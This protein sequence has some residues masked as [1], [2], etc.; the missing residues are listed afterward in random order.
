TPFR[1]LLD[2]EASGGRKGTEADALSFADFVRSAHAEMSEAERASF[3]KGLL[4][5]DYSIH[6]HVF[7]RS[8]FERVLLHACAGSTVLALAGNA[9]EGQLEHIAILRKDAPPDRRPVDVVIPIYN[10]RELTR[11]CVESVL[12]HS[13]ADA[14]IVLLDDA[15]S[16]PGITEDLD[17]FARR[18]R[19]V[20][21]RNEKNEG[22]V[23][24]ANRG[25]RHAA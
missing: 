18:E 5:T 13:P 21:L 17:A 6:F 22:F 12:R 7:D 24:T 16:D 19:V 20:V 14:R 8:L 2:D 9:P 25:M 23:K 4:E 3:V 15:S 10:A 1:H 11:R